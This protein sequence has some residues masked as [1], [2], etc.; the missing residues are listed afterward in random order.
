[1][2]VYSAPVLLMA[3]NSIRTLADNKEQ[4]KNLELVEKYSELMTSLKFNL[5]KSSELSIL[6]K[7]FLT[8]AV[9]RLDSEKSRSSTLGLGR[10]KLIESLFYMIKFDLFN[11]KSS[12][13]ETKLFERL[14]GLM[15]K[16][17]MNNVLHNEI[18]K[19][20][21]FILESDEG[22]TLVGNVH[23]Y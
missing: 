18:V 11:L 7:D 22:E 19:V 10:I 21:T 12:I 8:K 6:F 3:L 9:D 15:K 16:Y 20:I 17:Q 23:L 5:A 14:F 13:P 4:C 1:M 2:A